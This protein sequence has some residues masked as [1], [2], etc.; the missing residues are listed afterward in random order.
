MSEPPSVIELWKQPAPVRAIILGKG[1]S[2]SQFRPQE[3]PD[4]VVFALNEAVTAR[5][6]GM[7]VRV[8]YFVFIDA[9]AETI[10]NVPDTAIPIRGFGRFGRFGS[11]GY[12]FKY[13]R[14][15][16]PECPRG[17]ATAKAACIIG[18]WVKRRAAGPIELLFV[19]CDSWDNNQWTDETQYADCLP[20]IVGGRE[21]SYASCNGSLA[22]VL[23]EFRDHLTPR[24][25]HREIAGGRIYSEAV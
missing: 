16:P 12:W 11:V 20:K 10:E 1:P 21:L 18:E 23:V 24:W 15:L 2:L 14:D 13:G 4:S 6:G 22:K 25:F 5:P 8:D 3:Y 9:V 19:G 7:P 17:G